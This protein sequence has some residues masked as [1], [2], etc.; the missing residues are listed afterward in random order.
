MKKYK[1][2]NPPP[3]EKIRHAN[4]KIPD[5]EPLFDE[6]KANPR[7]K[8]IFRKLLC[9]N[10]GKIFLSQFIFVIKASP[11]FVAPV[12][13]TLLIDKAVDTANAGQG[14]A[15]IWVSAAIYG[16][17]LAAI[18]LQN[19]PTHILWARITNNMTRSVSAGLKKALVHKLQRLSVTYHKEMESGKLQAKFLRDLEAVDGLFSAVVNSI[20]PNIISTLIFVGISI[21]RSGWVSLFFL[22]VIP[23][24]LIMVTVYRKK[25]RVNAR[26]FRVAN[27]S[28]SSNLSTMMQMHQITK[29]HGLEDEQNNTVRK[30]IEN[31][32]EKGKKSDKAV[33]SFGSAVFA[34]GGVLQVGCLVLCVLLAVNKMISVGDIALYQALFANISGY[35]QALLGSFP[36]INSGAE[37]VRSVSEVMT[38]DEIEKSGTRLIPINGEIEFENVSFKYSDGG[39]SVVK[40]FS[41]HIKP[42]D[43][44][45]L[46]GAS[47]SGKSTLCNLII[48]LVSA[49]EGQLLIDGVPLQQLDLTQY[50]RNIAVVP[51]NAI[52]FPGTVK[53]NITYGLRRYSDEE[54]QEALDKANVTE[55][56][57]DLPKGVDTNTGELGG[58][59]SGGQRQRI[60]IARALIRNPKILILDEATSALDNRSEKH[61]QQAIAESIK[62]RTTIIVA[63]RL[64][65]IR[66]ADYIVVMREG[67]CAE[68]GTYQELVEKRGIF[69]EMDRLNSTELN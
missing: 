25:M 8:G 33:A 37:A 6:N 17:I 1:A 57:K 31:V 55:F 22:A 30:G 14:L 7:S 58:L 56:I 36:T 50:R 20:I 35:A 27:E 61:I 62:N 68:S 40:N 52:L 34:F 59:L 32:M 39:A 16:A 69:Y 66:N 19:I 4:N 51:Q 3:K 45:A 26:A 11:L 13:I 12:M 63:H 67:E 23:I 43:C 42:G 21:Y 28:L 5:Y 65:T 24:N 48:G 29:S 9:I 38:S 60:T 10:F 15:D 54:L 41:L 53:E 18:F 49:T 44:V 64:S 2:Q 47:G 46:V